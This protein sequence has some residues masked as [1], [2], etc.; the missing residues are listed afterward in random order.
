LANGLTLIHQQA[1]V[2]L[3]SLQVWF[4]TGSQHEGPLLGCGVAHFLEHMLFKGTATRS[5]TDISREVAQMGGSANAYTTYDRTVYY[6][7]VPS[8]A[9]SNA[10]DLMADMCFNAALP[11]AEFAS[12]RDVILREID[13]GL[14]DP[15]QQFFQSFTQTAFREHPFKHPIIGHRALFEMLSHRDLLDTYRARY[16]PQN[17]VVV[18]VGGLTE[19]QV[20][21]LAKQSFGKVLMR[22]TLPVS[23][24]VEP[25]Q[26][27]PRTCRER[28]D[29]QVVRGMVGWKI[30]GFSSPEAPALKV[31]AHLLGNGQSSWLWQALREHRGLVHQIEA[32]CWNPGELGLLYVSYLCDPDKSEATEA[33]LNEELQQ[34][35]ATEPADDQLAKVIRQAEVAIIDSQKTVSGL[36]SRLGSAEVVAGELGF[37]QAQLERLRQVR[38]HDLLNAGRRYLVSSGQTTATLMPQQDTPKAMSLPLSRSLPDAE[39]NR[40]PNGARLITQRGGTVPK[41]HLKLVFT[42][43]SVHEAAGQRGLTGILSTMLR[44][45]TSSR[46]ALEVAE[47]VES[48][49]G[50]FSEFCGNN[51]F[52][53]SLEFLSEDH[54]VV[55][56]LLEEALLAPAL[57]PQ[58]F[59]LEREA[60][61]AAL[62]EDE[63]D[64]LSYARRRLRSRF[65]AGHPYAVDSLGTQTDLE[66][67]SIDHLKQLFKERVVGMQTIAALTGSYHE[68]LPAALAAILSKLPAGSQLPAL[69]AFALPHQAEHHLSAPRQ[70]AI[71][72]ESYR[73][74]GI[75]EPAY[76]TSEVLDELFSGMAS[77]LF[78]QVREE[79]GLAYYVGSSRMVGHHCGQFSFYA[80]THPEA[81]LKVF[82]AYTEEIQRVQ[83]GDFEPG[84]LDACRKRLAVRKRSGRQSPGSRA[85]ELALTTVY[86][87]PVNDWRNY[88]EHISAVTAQMLAEHAQSL[89]QPAHRVRLLLQPES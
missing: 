61:L 29:V 6:V 9:A 2:D 86:G 35:L 39:L 54:A 21:S 13:M 7:D 3:L 70:Q 65:F 8:E 25:Q 37:M 62:K 56:D 82:E 34:F 14:D 15:D 38:A 49:G 71:V 72:L 60:Q 63:D 22:P 80:G 67:L 64:V 68:G 85:M 42:G 40:L 88:D 23:T 89:F 12:E 5:P 31:L 44:R 84:E 53:L 77:R 45:A 75:C 57:Q 20:M 58:A 47:L 11:E 27:A 28:G 55:C 59:D 33:A 79:Q 76:F 78:R 36:A 19:T 43:G 52:G 51:T 81:A 73:D 74:V 17:A 24:P 26:L 69:P 48:R 10:F 32:G 66:A 30:P 41:T 83:A 50:H 46:S 18:V 16:T 1:P 4:K 87:R